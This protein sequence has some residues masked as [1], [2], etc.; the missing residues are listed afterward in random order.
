MQLG[1]R[2]LPLHAW[3]AGSGHG[4][5]LSSGWALSAPLHARVGG[6]ECPPEP[7]CAQYSCGSPS[8][9]ELGWGCCAPQQ[10]REELERGRDSSTA[11]GSGTKAQWLQLGLS[12][13]TSA[14][15]WLS[16]RLWVP[17]SQGSGVPSMPWIQPCSAPSAVSQSGWELLAQISGLALHLSLSLGVCRNTDTHQGQ[18]RDSSDGTTPARPSQLGCAE[19]S[20]PSS[21]LAGSKGAQVNCNAQT[22][23]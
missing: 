13:L 4:V 6:T 18:L 8:K 7:G 10:F 22:L 21:F 1:R 11:P 19:L 9:E 3:Q 16:D 12:S 14:G 20:H 5:C 15:P 2:L 17:L 23:T